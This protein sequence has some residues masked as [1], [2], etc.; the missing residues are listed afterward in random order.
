[1]S[2]EPL[3]EKRSL[4]ISRAALSLFTAV[5]HW[6]AWFDGMIRRTTLCSLTCEQ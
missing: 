6:N 5:G 4:C 1:M 2:D 3:F